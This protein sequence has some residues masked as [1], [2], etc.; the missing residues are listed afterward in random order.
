MFWK[1]HSARQVCRSMRPEVTQR[2]LNLT[3]QILLHSFLLHCSLVSSSHQKSCL[4]YSAKVTDLFPLGSELKSNYNNIFWQPELHACKNHGKNRDRFGGTIINIIHYSSALFLSHQKS[5]I[6]IFFLFY[7]C[8]NPTWFL[9]STKKE[10][11]LRDWHFDQTLQ[12]QA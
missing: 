12:K 10:I 8:V 2:W 1:V 9:M 3:L 5:N 7:F 6:Y 11:N 4:Q